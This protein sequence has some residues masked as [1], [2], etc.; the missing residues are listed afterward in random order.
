MVK[1]SFGQ[2]WRGS[3]YKKGEAMPATGKQAER[4][5]KCGRAYTEL[6]RPTDRNTIAQIKEYLDKDGVSYD[7]SLTKAEL[8]ELC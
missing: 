2:F 3:Y 5:V 8:L 7:A 1:A 4:L 6:D